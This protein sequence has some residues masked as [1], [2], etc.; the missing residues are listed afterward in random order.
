[1]VRLLFLASALAQASP[2]PQDHFKIRVLDDVTGRGVPLVELRT[3]ND[4]SYV[5]D[6]NGL[7]AFYEPGLMDK[8]VF[9]H[10]S[11][12]GY[13]FPKDGFGYRGQRL[14]VTPGGEAVL[15]IKRLN[16][17][18]RLYRVTGAGSYRDS[19]L[20]GEPTPLKHP[21]LNGLVFGS[22]SVITALYRD[23]IYWFWGDT[24]RPAYPLGNFHSPGATSLL[25]T[26]G[27]LAPEVGVELT[28]FL[29]AD[30]FAKPTCQMAGDGPTWISALFTLPNSQGQ[31]RLWASYVKIKPPLAVYAR[32]LAEFN[33]E[34]QQFEHRIAFSVDAPATPDGHPF[35]H[36]VQDVEYLYFADAYPLLRVPA[37]L[38]KVQDLSNYEVF[39]CLRA[40]SRAAEPELDRDAQGRLHYAWRS[41]TVPWSQD[42]QKKLEKKGRIQ[43]GE[44]LH[45]L[46]EADTGQPITTHRGSVYWNAYRGR[47]AMLTVES[48]GTSELG[49]VWYAE[50]DEPVG[51]WVYARKI[52]THHKYSFYNPKQHPLFDADQGRVLF[53]EGTYT[54]SFSGNEQRTP[55]YD[56]NQIMY[57]LDLSDSRLV[58]P[59][60]VYR[61]ADDRGGVRFVTGQRT[62]NVGAAA[63]IAFFA[64][65][66]PRPDAVP[67]R[68]E[69]AHGHLRLLAGTAPDVAGSTAPST[70]FYALPAE[71]PNPPATTVPLYEFVGADGQSWAYAS[72]TDPGPPGF[73]K[74]AQPVCRVWKQTIRY[75]TD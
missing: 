15:K 41:A 59:V 53:F 75:V 27:G 3:V 16:I 39:T 58:L 50:A 42:L 35:R 74:N 10:V 69:T 37:T 19:L 9:F 20:L 30:G 46:R 45:Q 65:D 70:A 33:D 52:V 73:Q 68:A 2:G 43:A 14:Q 8:A 18:E 4:I 5:T 17:A 12:H 38:Q 26:A 64:L 55:R 47:W 28:Y 60:A 72:D 40:G 61:S 36:T 23:K 51:P 1:M 56:Y 24:N 63:P 62:P 49:E 6:S 34:T 71:A 54:D 13:E 11:S 25:P 57:R 29:A 48:H 66:R 44:G 32:G 67:I 31:E 7:V 22:D 21:V